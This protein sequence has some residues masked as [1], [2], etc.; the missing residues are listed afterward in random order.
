M[1]RK[2]E[3]K[4]FDKATQEANG[5]SEKMWKVI[6]KA[7]K[8]RPKA[9]TVPDFV[10]VQT[11][12]GTQVKLNKTSEIVDE[13]NRQFAGM[14][15]NLAKDLKTTPTPTNFT[16]FLPTPNPNHDILILHHVTEAEVFNL[17]Q[18][19]DPSKSTGYDEVPPRILKWASSILSPILSQLFNKCLVSGIY[20]D[21]L[22]TARVKPIF[23]G[24]NKN[25]P[26][27]YRP[28]S[29]LSQFFKPMIVIM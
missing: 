11:A 10:K 21:S 19:L 26:S 1:K 13:L 16:E 27:S 3:R 5:D 12:E 4:Y 22:K 23:K 9:H 7:T 15:A 14:G 17:I 8:Q 2:A 25:D 20:P 29:I 28:I 24:G 6:K 18:N